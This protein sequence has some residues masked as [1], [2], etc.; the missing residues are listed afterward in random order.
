MSRNLR[1]EDPGTVKNFNDI[2]HTSFFRHDIYQNIHDINNR[3]IY[4]ISTH[5]AQAFERVD[6]LI[7][8]IMHTKY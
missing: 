8:G 2:I 1:L 6:K 3:A 4:T 7:T 5:K